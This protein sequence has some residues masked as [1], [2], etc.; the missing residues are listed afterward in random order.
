VEKILLIKGAINTINPRGG[1]SLNQEEK[2]MVYRKKQLTEKGGG[3]MSGGKE[4]STEK[5]KEPGAC[6]FER[7]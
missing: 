2:P 3:G 5:I 6:G 7:D 4:H 1:G